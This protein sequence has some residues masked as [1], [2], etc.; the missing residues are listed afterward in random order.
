M[1]RRT[2]RTRVHAVLAGGVLLLSAGTIRAAEIHVVRF[3][4]DIAQVSP[5]LC[6]RV[7]W[8]D[9]L[10]FRNTTGQ[11]LSVR[12]LSVSNGFELTD[13]D[14]L[15][16]PAHQIRSVLIVPQPAESAVRTNWTP[17]NQPFIL[18]VNRLEVP[19]GVVVESRGEIYG[20]GPQDQPLPC[21]I[22]IPLG[23][24][25][26]LGSISLPVVRTLTPAGV[27]HVSLA[28]DAG[29][30][31]QRTN[32]SVYNG[33]ASPANVR[34]E[35]RRSCDDVAVAT[36]TA[37]V[38]PASVAQFTGL[39]DPGG[40]GCSRTGVPYFSRYAVVL[41]DQPGFSFVTSLVADVPPGIT[42]TS[43]APR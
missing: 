9:H 13:P 34:I 8:R 24:D 15:L 30:R 39:S 43:T 11:D 29:T 41:M 31:R 4:T 27:E 18:L 38:P 14:P 28:A 2:L 17:R 36:R 3:W 37:V 5:T 32:V 21:P 19:D 33:G 1:A 42:I 12:A 10:L 25:S 20:P 6:Y 7:G 23:F 40:S 16:I 22:S 26:V 35:L